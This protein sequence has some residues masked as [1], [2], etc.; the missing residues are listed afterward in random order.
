MAQYR[1]QVAAYGSNDP[2]RDQCINTVYFDTDLDPLTGTNPGGLVEDT[3]KAFGNT[4]QYGPGID[5]L[6]GKIYKM[7]DPEPRVPLKEYE[8]QFAASAAAGAPREVALC[9]SFYAGVNQ[10][11]RRGRLY[12][13]PFRAADMALR[14]AQAVRDR[15][16]TLAAA[17]SGIGGANVQWVQHSPTTGEFHNVTNWWVDDE[18]DTMRSRGLKATVRTTGTV[19]G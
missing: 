11:R 12:I 6:H 8:L 4:Q 14:P 13:G 3:V 17:L 5:R 19:N 15:I 7:S 16:G 18:W 10:P 1:V 9:L 2:V